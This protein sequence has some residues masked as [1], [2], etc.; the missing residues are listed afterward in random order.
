MAILKLALG[1][2]TLAGALCAQGPEPARFLR[3]NVVATDNRGEPAGDLKAEDFRVTDDG[4]PQR[5]SLFRGGGSGMPA[6]V[7]GGREFFNR[8]ASPH[9]T[10]ILFDF[11]NETRTDLLEASRKMGQSLKGLESGESLYFYLLLMDGKLLPIHGIEKAPGDAPDKTWVQ[12]IE[13]LL[14]KAVKTQ[15]GTRPAGMLQE[16]VVKRTYVGLETLAK[17]MAALPGRREIVWVTNG[18]PSVTNPK[19]PCSGDWIDCALYVPHLS[20][21]LDSAGA[22]VNPFSYSSLLGPDTTRTMEEMAG[23]TGGRTYF[24][25]D[26][27]TVVTQLA[28][29]A[30]GVYSLAYEPPREDWDNKFHKVKVT[31]ERKGV[32]IQARQRYY[33]LPDTR[34]AAVRQQAALVAAYQSPSDISYIGLRAALSP[35]ADPQKTVRVEMRVDPADLLLEDR[36]G[37][38]EGQITVLFSA[39]TAAGPKG[40]PTLANLALH[41][42]KEQ[43]ETAAKEGIPIAREYAIDNTIE[44]VRLIV[45]DLGADSVG[46]LTMPYVP[47]K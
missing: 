45:L 30:S 36:G 43:R 11:L 44:K 39:R 34:S 8:A 27:R 46:S 12:D 28:G 9:A 41:L 24:S 32:K 25:E 3:L 18:V 31:C 5:I 20:V 17:Q 2:L 37:T 42:T 15:A 33:G 29:A 35:G 6:P 7:Q 1:S 19:T 38:W 13:A 16:E 4:K 14:A 21:T 26:M 23:L 47:G 10:A 40:E 22:V